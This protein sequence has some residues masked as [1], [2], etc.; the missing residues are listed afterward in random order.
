MSTFIGLCVCAVLCF[1]GLYGVITDIV[2][3]H[4]LWAI[5][6]IFSSGFVAVIRGVA[7]YY[8]YIGY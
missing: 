5:F 1:F 4:I 2:H 3:G 8:G 6:D 7:F